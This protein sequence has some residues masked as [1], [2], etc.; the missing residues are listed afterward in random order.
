MQLH[1]ARV[2]SG[3]QSVTRPG[4]GRLSVTACSFVVSILTTILIAHILTPRTFGVYMF[5][6]WLATVAVPA[7]GIGMSALTSR[8]ITGIQSQEDLRVAAGIF[9]FVWRRQ[10]RRMLLYCLVYFGLV[11]PFSW[12]FGASAPLLYL[13]LAGLA[14]LPQLL[15]GVASI[16]LRSLR[17]F[18]LLSAIHLFGTVATLLL[19]LLA[20]QQATDLVGILLLVSVIASTV[21][22][23]MAILCILRLLPLRQTTAP[24]ILLK[25]RLTRGLN[26]SLLLFTLDLIVWQRGELLLLAYRRDTAELGFYALSSIICIHVIV[27]APALLATCILPLLLQYVPSQRYTSASDAYVKTSRYVALL[28]SPLCISAIIFCPGIIAFSLGSAYL[29]VVAPLRI[30]LVA[31]IFGSIATVSLTYL[32]HG[33]RKKVQIRLGLWAAGVNL[34]LAIPCIAFWGVT[35]AAIATAIAQIISATGSIVICKHYLFGRMRTS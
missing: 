17:R 34:F 30:M 22:L 4:V 31:A 35:G 24:S 25:D 23:C 1:Q 13:C 21:T 15:S 3:K 19:V 29:P 5:V 20:S 6:L 33:E 12:V 7:I 28:A 11:W 18:D 26:N 14:A 27:F 10:Y 16:T 32:A 9:S 8:Y 2:L